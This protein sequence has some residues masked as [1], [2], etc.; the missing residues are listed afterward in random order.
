MLS[1][2]SKVIEISMK[3]VQ[4]CCDWGLMHI[5]FRFQTQLHLLSRLGTLWVSSV[6]FTT[7]QR[8]LPH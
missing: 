6:D 1:R 3:C 5:V 7:I 4:V 2:A 8:V